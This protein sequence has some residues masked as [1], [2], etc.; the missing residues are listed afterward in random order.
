MRYRLIPVL[1]ALALAAGCSS[2]TPTPPAAATTTSAAVV[3]SPTSD[4][5][6]FAQDYNTDVAP[7]LKGNGV[8]GNAYMT[9]MTDA[10]TKLAATLTGTGPYSETL[11]KDALAVAADPTSY[12]ALAAFNT[13][14]QPYLSQCGMTSGAT[15]S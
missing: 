6:A 13:D 2:S 9:E 10:F 3:A 11:R 14:L 5:S 4:C 12:T 8:T 15:A 1:A 7:V